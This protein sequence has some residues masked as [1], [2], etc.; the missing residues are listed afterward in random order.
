MHRLHAA[1]VLGLVALAM[2]CTSS[3]APK[4]PAIATTM[5]GA[6]AGD[7]ITLRGR[8]SEEPAQH[9]MT[10]VAGKAEA[11]FDLAGKEQIIVYWTAPPNCAKDVIVTGKVIEQH[12]ESRTKAGERYTELQVDVDSVRC[13]GD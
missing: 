12:G 13:E 11:Y 9:L 8:V 3:P 6:K 4:A 7:T 2:G 5:A 10:G 1:G